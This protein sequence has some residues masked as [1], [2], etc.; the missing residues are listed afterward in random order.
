MRD[1][2]YFRTFVAL[3]YLLALVVHGRW[4]MRTALLTL[5]VV[6]VW[7][8]PLLR[9]ARRHRATGRAVSAR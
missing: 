9:D 1:A 6:A 3:A 7:A 8:L 4:E 2:S 5:A